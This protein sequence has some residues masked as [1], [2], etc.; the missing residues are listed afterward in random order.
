M[1]RFRQY[2]INAATVQRFQTNGYFVNFPE[3]YGD[4]MTRGM[5]G[6]IY[7]R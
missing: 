3:L 5:D 7:L 4:F 2:K 1:S 6:R